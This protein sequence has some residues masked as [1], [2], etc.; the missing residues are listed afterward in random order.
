MVAHGVR[1]RGESLSGAG[2][3][4]SPPLGQVTS[5]LVRDGFGLVLEADEWDADCVTRVV[6]ETM[7]D[8]GDLQVPLRMKERM[9]R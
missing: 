6:K 4:L 3:V 2:I 5:Q 8:A 7:E 9:E 1:L